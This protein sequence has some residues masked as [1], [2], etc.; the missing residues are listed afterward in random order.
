M[1]SAAFAALKVLR[2]L[3]A[4]RAQICASLRREGIVKSLLG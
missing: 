1:A 3:I 4:W 2:V